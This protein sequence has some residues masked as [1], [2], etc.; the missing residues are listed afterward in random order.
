[1]ETDIE[2][3]LIKICHWEIKILHKRFFRM[4]AEP[5]SVLKTKL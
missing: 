2:L 3:Y 4:E 1:M 5:A